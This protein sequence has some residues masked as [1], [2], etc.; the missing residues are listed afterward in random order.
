MEAIFGLRKITSGTITLK[1]QEVRIKNP[2]DAI[3]KGIS[4]LTEDRR[5]KGIVGIR[6]ITDNTILSN[7]RAYST[8]LNHRKIRED[9]DSYVAKLRVKTPNSEELIKNLSGGNQQKVLVNKQYS[10]QSER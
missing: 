10:G 6:D 8:P 2:V 5:G 9:V 1:G 3:A 7:L 4:F